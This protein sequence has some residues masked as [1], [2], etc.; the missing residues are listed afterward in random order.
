M[1]V[2]RLIIYLVACEHG[3]ALQQQQP[4]SITLKL[5]LQCQVLYFQNQCVRQVVERRNGLV[6]I[7]KK[8]SRPIDRYRPRNILNMRAEALQ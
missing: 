6:L 8:M 1:L 3:F 4:R 7:K 5:R 2:N